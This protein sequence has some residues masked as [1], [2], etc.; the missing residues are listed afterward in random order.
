MEEIRY[1]LAQHAFGH[2]QLTPQVAAG[3]VEGIRYGWIGL[4]TELGHDPRLGVRPGSSS[5]ESG[6]DSERDKPDFPGLGVGPET[7]R[8]SS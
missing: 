7:D 6:T 2:C 4:A 5:G 8:F 1:G 3:K